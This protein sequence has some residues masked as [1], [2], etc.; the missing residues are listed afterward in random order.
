MLQIPKLI[1]L[2]EQWFWGSVMICESFCL[3]MNPGYYTIW[4]F[5][6]VFCSNCDFCHMPYMRMWLVGKNA[7]NVLTKFQGAGTHL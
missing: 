3:R 1:L 6:F 4:S 2:K 5:L 7:N